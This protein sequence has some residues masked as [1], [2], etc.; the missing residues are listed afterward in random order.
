[1]PGIAL[2]DPVN[3][4]PFIAAAFFGSMVQACSY[5]VEAHYNLSSNEQEIDRE[6]PRWLAAKKKREEQF[7]SALQTQ[8]IA[9]A[10]LTVLAMISALQSSYL[11]AILITAAI[12]LALISVEVGPMIS[13]FCA[14]GKNNHWERLADWIEERGPSYRL[15]LSKLINVGFALYAAYY[16]R[17]N[18]ILSTVTALF[19]SLS[20]LMPF[21]AKKVSI[22]ESDEEGLP[23][24]ATTLSDHG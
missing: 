5:K 18:P 20:L 3:C 1:M 6:S 14:G 23:P 10:G 13:R 11:P 9:A 8:Q 15:A 19:G 4:F 2:F 22:R 24:K 12:G 7:A 16:N 17:G 21:L